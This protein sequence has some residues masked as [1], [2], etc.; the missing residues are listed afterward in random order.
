MTIKDFATCAQLAQD[1]GYDGVEVIARL[2]RKDSFN[3]AKVAR[4]F[5]VY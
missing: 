1:S 4:F 3:F 5:H 2:K